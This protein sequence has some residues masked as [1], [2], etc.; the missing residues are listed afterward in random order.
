[1]GSRSSFEQHR[2]LP[3]SQGESAHQHPLQSDE[4]SP[5]AATLSNNRGLGER[6]APVAWWM[7]PWIAP[8]DETD[9]PTGGPTPTPAP[10]SKKRRDANATDLPT[11]NSTIPRGAALPSSALKS[12]AG[13]GR[14]GGHFDSPVVPYKGAKYP[15][16]R[17]ASRQLE[18][19]PRAGLNWASLAAVVAA[20]AYE[21]YPLH[22][23]YTMDGPSPSLPT[24]LADIHWDEPPIPSRLPPS[25]MKY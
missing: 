15:L 21:S 20:R 25:S 16:A 24:L 3:R 8:L 5:P 19:G 22:G 9:C 2:G 4:P 7:P 11:R 18:P 1:M 17:L 10:P 13:V 6:L 23:K 14:R 12:A